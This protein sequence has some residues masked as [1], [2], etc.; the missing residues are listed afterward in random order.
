MGFKH[1]AN[2]V[3]QM[4]TESAAQLLVF[5]CAFALDQR[6]S[7]GHDNRRNTLL[8]SSRVT[9]RAQFLRRAFPN[10]VP[11]LW[12]PPLTHYDANGDIDT[13]RMTAHWRYLSACV[14]G[15]L[16]PGSTGDGWEL[17]KG[18][19]RQLITVGLELAGQLNLQVLIGT[20]HPD[21]RET[22]ALIQ[23]DVS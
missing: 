3:H 19:R 11:R 10:G 21:A 13:N 15:V 12:C 22:L 20:L 9:A 2:N 1:F 23:E 5:I 8:M 14:G 7:P 6:Q 16:I 17:T 18:E 4:G